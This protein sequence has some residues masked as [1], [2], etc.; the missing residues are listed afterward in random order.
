M[1]DVWQLMSFIH[2]ITQGGFLIWY[3]IFPIG[4]SVRSDDWDARGHGCVHRGPDI[5]ISSLHDP[6]SASDHRGL[7]LHH[8]RQLQLDLHYSASRA[9]HRHH[10]PRE[11]HWWYVRMEPAV[12]EWWNYTAREQQCVKPDVM[13]WSAGFPTTNKDN[14]R[15]GILIW[16]QPVCM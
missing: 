6:T 14:V 7:Q 1:Q 11:Q 8:W 2:L 5:P 16:G 15:R 4:R 10:G 12:T 9:K 3:P 13:N